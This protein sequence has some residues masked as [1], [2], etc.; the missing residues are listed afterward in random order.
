[1]SWHPREHLEVRN[2]A[3]ADAM[4][5]PWKGKKWGALLVVDDDDVKHT[6]LTDDI[7]YHRL[8][9]GAD[10]AMRA[11]LEVPPGVYFLVRPGWPG[12]PEW[13]T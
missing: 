11:D 2:R 6:L 7:K 1:M 13:R 3:E 12:E 8:L 4:G 10:D 9:V 5:I